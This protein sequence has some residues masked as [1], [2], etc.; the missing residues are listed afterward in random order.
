MALIK[1]DVITQKVTIYGILIIILTFTTCF[2][3]S[4]IPSF[5]S[6][7]IDIT[8]N[9]NS[10]LRLEREGA[11][12]GPGPDD[13]DPEGALE[14]KSDKPLK[15]ENKK[16]DSNKKDSSGKKED[17]KAGSLIE[18][19]ATIANKGCTDITFDAYFIVNGQKINDSRQTLNIAAGGQTNF[20]YKCIQ[21][22]SEDVVYSVSTDDIVVLSV[23]NFDINS[24]EFHNLGGSHGPLTVILLSLP[25]FFMAILVYR[26]FTRKSRGSKKRR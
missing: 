17:K 3:L 4:N 2:C 26:Y 5:T 11:L 25:A 18:L 6:E 22:K 13:D 23:S 12:E 21:K 8:D 16:E 9:P 24:K 14:G 1:G 19:T 15:A 20:T 10:K 7:N